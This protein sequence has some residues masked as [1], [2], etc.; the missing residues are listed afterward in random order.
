MLHGT[1]QN[2]NGV[3]E[4]PI[5]VE[6]FNVVFN[7]VSPLNTEIYEGPRLGFLPFAI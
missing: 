1:Y 6:S 7:A 4:G 2:N 3:M 5:R